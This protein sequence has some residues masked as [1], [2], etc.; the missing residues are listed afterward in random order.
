PLEGIPSWLLP[1]SYVLPPTYAVHGLRSV[2]L[3]GWGLDKIW[4]D[5]L[6]LALFEVIFLVL[7]M[8]KLKRWEA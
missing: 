8:L 1:L 7:A 5:I 6:A 2:L 4:L 3:K